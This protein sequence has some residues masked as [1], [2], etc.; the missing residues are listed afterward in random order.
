M[1][2][3]IPFLI[4]A[5]T[6]IALDVGIKHAMGGQS[7]NRSKI[8][9]VALGVIPGITLAKYM[10]KGFS[11]LKQ[12]SDV[13]F[14]KARGL[15]G[16][17][18]PYLDEAYALSVIHADDAVKLVSGGLKG[19][20]MHLSLNAAMDKVVEDSRGPVQSLTSRT[21]SPRQPTKIL[22]RSAQNTGKKTSRRTVSSRKTGR[23]TSYCKVH[24]KY[25]F[26]EKYNI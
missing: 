21:E 2:V 20:A 7:T 12:A 15:S 23:N 13:P 11:I 18:G 5:G 1:P 24:R 10:P 17:V 8:E 16:Q 19:L 22:A 6:N 26:C 25:D 4:S 3:F 14:Y 9:S